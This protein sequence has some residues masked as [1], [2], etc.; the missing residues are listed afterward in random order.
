MSLWYNILAVVVPDH[1]I[2]WK[3]GSTTQG[4]S[5]TLQ[6]SKLQTW[7]SVLIAQ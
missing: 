1:I 2:M 4:A 5:D 3:N 6:W 7:F